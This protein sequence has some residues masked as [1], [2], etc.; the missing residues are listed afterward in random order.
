MD[1]DLQALDFHGEVENDSAGFTILPAGD[2]PFTVE[3]FTRE[4][5]MPKEGSKLPQCKV[6]VLKIKIHGNE[7]GDSTITERIYMVQRSEGKICAFFVSIGMRVKGEKFKMNFEGAPGKSGIC[8]VKIEPYN[9]KEYNKID[10]YLP[11]PETP[12]DSPA[13]ENKP[14]STGFTPGQ[15]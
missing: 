3:Q 2:Y 4:E 7:L 14:E 15:F 6:A 12:T 1:D 13:T 10:W 11:R 8:K 5:Y 9:G